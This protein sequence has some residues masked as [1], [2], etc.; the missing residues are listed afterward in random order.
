MKYNKK[1]IFWIESYENHEDWFVVGVDQFI[2]ET[3]FC[4]NNGYDLDLVS[5]EEICLV[6]YEN[7]EDI[8]EEAYFP[9]HELLV[10]NGFEIITDDEP[11]IFWKSGRKFCQGNIIQNIL[12][13][14]G[15]KKFGVYIIEVRDTGLYKIGVTKDI[16]K[17]ISQLQTSNPY[18]FYL[19]DFFVTPKSWELERIL[20]NK[21]KLNRYKREWFKL[22][23]DEITEACKFAKKFIG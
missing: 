11:R 23:N 6:E 19:I 16:K 2:A 20:H 14:R 13:L 7:E 21:Y 5:S 12:M 22:N 4:D 9:S 1:S 10:K 3:F 8:L 17:R 18:E 15:S